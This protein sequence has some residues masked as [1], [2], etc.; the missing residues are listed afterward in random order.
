MRDIRSST[1]CLLFLLVP[2]PTRIPIPTLIL[3]H[4]CRFD[5]VPKH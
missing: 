5:L 3:A 1:L 4:A 2:V